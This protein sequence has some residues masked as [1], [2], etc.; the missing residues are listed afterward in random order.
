MVENHQGHGHQGR[1]MPDARSRLLLAMSL[2][3]CGVAIAQTP[4]PQY[5]NRP[6]RIIVSVA[7]GGGTDTVGRSLAQKMSERLG[8]QFVIDNRPGGGGSIAVEL[9]ARAHPDGHTLLF[10]SSTF[11]TNQLLYKVSYDALRDLAPVSLAS[12]NAYV[13]AVNAAVPAKTLQ[14]FVALAKA[15]PRGFNYASSGKGGLVHLTGELVSV[16]TGIEMTHIP[17]KGMALAFPDVISGQVHVAISSALTMQPHLRGGRVHA[18][19]VSSRS[20]MPALPEV[21]TIAESGYPGFEVTQWYGMMAPAQT[22]LAIRL[23]LQQEI[24]RAL[25]IPEVRAR[26]SA[27][28]ADPVGNTPQE[29]AARLK[30]E[31]AKWAKTIKAAGIKG[32]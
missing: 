32:D 15:K 14:A 19:G 12:E 22:P 5:P 13:F 11:V 2:C 30:E 24:S 1:V 6:V 27:E 29:F 28:G 20:R 3:V 4:Y 10:S 26:L 23:T 17:Y 8:Q 21:P 18:L 25:Q 9:T 31:F 16:A 7:A